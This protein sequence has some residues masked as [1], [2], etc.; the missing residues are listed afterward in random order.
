MSSRTSIDRTLP[1]IGSKNWGAT[2]NNYL[3]TQEYETQSL[4]N[5]IEQITEQQ[6]TV[7]ETVLSSGVNIESVDSMLPGLYISGTYVT[8]G[9]QIDTTK[10]YVYKG[11]A[12]VVGAAN[13]SSRL[14]SPAKDDLT[15]PVSTITAELGLST[16]TPGANARCVYA[17]Y[18]I[19]S[20]TW[21]VKT[22][23]TTT[24]A[25]ETSISLNPYYICLG[26]LWGY[27]TSTGSPVYY[28][29]Y[30]TMKSN[31]SIASKKWMLDEPHAMVN[32]FLNFNSSDKTLTGSPLSTSEGCMLH[33]QA[34]GINPFTT[35]SAVTSEINADLTSFT[36]STLDGENTKNDFVVLEK[37]ESSFYVT[38]ASSD[39]ITLQS[40][41]S[42]KIHRLSATALSMG[43]KA[44][45]LL[46]ADA[47]DPLNT[48]QAV[49][50]DSDFG[51]LWYYADPVELY[52]LQG[53][54]M[55][56]APGNGISTINANGLNPHVTS[57]IKNDDELWFGEE[58]ATVDGEGNKTGG[59]YFHFK[60]EGITRQ[61]R[62]EL[63]VPDPS[64]FSSGE[65]DSYVLTNNMNYLDDTEIKIW[66]RVNYNEE[67]NIHHALDID[68][69]GAALVSDLNTTTSKIN[70]EYNEIKLNINSGEEETE[71]ASVIISEDIDS[72]Y[73]T[74]TSTADNMIFNI[75]DGESLTINS[76]EV[77]IL[78]SDT[79]NTRL[80]IGE[81]PSKGIVL[82]EGR[83]A[84]INEAFIAV[85]GDG[86][87]LSPNGLT[88][89]SDTTGVTIGTIAS[90]LPWQVAD[91]GTS[92]PVKMISKQAGVTLAAGKKWY[93]PITSIWKISFTSKN[94]ETPT[95]KYIA[96]GAING[97]LQPFYEVDE[98]GEIT[99]TKFLIEGLEWTYASNT[100][101]TVKIVSKDEITD[102]NI[103]ITVYEWTQ[104][105]EPPIPLLTIGEMAQNSRAD[106]ETNKGILNIDSSYST[107]TTNLNQFSGTM[108][109]T[110][111]SGNT[112]ITKNTGKVYV[113]T[114]TKDIEINNSTGASSNVIVRYSDKVEFT[115][116]KE[117]T[118]LGIFVSNNAYC[119]K[120][121]CDEDTN[122]QGIVSNYGNYLD[123]CPYG[124]VVQVVK[125]IYDLVY[126]HSQWTADGDGASGDIHRTNKTDSRILPIKYS[127]AM[128]YVGSNGEDSL[129]EW[130]RAPA[131]YHQW[132][133]ISMRVRI[134]SAGNGISD[135]INFGVTT[136]WALT[137]VQNRWA[138]F[139]A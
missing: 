17:Y 119:Q 18:D 76:T 24:P 63:I 83:V 114:N 28:W 108:N 42:S 101:R 50:K 48:S 133:K 45:L 100:F 81:D 60:T 130:E 82:S 2:L 132:I 116:C 4:A 27:C 66:N 99:D 95:T 47:N 31:L 110:E 67:N 71:R 30:K 62:V 51:R 120:S 40:Y 68:N 54:S 44:V 56:A 6:K 97:L 39:Q 34:L 12:T 74:I 84:G 106:I 118:N 43:G 123:G 104:S 121:L 139:Q 37:N 105:T 70:V 1:T 90:G 41:S 94:I 59:K 80:S 73:S 46:Q 77:A 65:Q 21:S 112:V 69:A 3:R 61:G 78:G 125:P 10:D 35:T 22:G 49:F 86:C 131:N 16:T 75:T 96:L 109:V 138:E 89:P 117:L 29:H 124:K 93:N 88:L 20:L 5:E 137:G 98:N 111:H 7:V 136:F 92:Q 32:T 128:K 8:E 127:T 103:Q 129:E 23:E 53:A 26:V 9:A 15:I 91:S 135:N 115:R 36:L 19:T 57:L 33:V 72:T 25:T 79:I 64:E 134:P 58:K 14:Q 11:Y 85:G 38:T 52:R 126:Q 13:I 107:S 122:M 102:K 55:Y 113:G 87:K